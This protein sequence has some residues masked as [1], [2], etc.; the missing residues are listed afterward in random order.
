MSVGDD[1]STP[2]ESLLEP[3][4]RGWNVKEKWTGLF[5]LWVRGDEAWAE[6]SPEL[7]GIGN[8][9]DRGY[10]AKAGKE[11]MKLESALWWLAIL[12][13]VESDASAKLLRGTLEGVSKDIVQ[14]LLD[15][16]L[17]KMVLQ[18]MSEK[19]EARAA[20]DSDRALN[21][22][23]QSMRGLIRT[24]FPSKAFG[25]GD[26]IPKELLAI[27]VARTLCEDF[28]RLPTKREV[29]ERLEAI[30]VSYEKSKDP[31]G[32]WRMLFARAGLSTL[33]D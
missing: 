4:L 9:L 29:R 17:G 16:R 5:T 31:D 7:Q 11:A 2:S 12:E 21:L 23:G 13:E 26:A 19:T 25:S 8:R 18:V 10:H 1:D 15:A 6:L 3:R 24:K 22:F 30:G 33:P 20:R 27:W 32:R 14:A 28:R